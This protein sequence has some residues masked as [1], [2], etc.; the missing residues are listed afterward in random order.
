MFPDFPYLMELYTP[1]ANQNLE[2][3]NVSYYTL[4]SQVQAM[5]SKNQTREN[6]SQ[7]GQNNTSFTNIRIKTG[8]LDGYLPQ[9]GDVLKLISNGSYFLVKNVYRDV[10]LPNFDHQLYIRCEC[11]DYNSNL[12]P[13]NLN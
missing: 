7:I 8:T 11:E 9:V 12:F 2:G 6:F 1:N 5:I 3:E 4:K 13:Q 10:Y